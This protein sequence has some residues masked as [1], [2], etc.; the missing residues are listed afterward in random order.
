MSSIRNNRDRRHSSRTSRE[1]RDNNNGVRNDK[2]HDSSFTAHSSPNPSPSHIGE[3]SDTDHLR[4]N[5]DDLINDMAERVATKTATAIAFDRRDFYYYRRKTSGRRCS[6]FLSET[7]AD[8]GCHVCLGVGIIGGYE[9]H[10]TITETLDFTSPDLI[11]VNCE[12]NFDQDTR[13]V[14][15]RLI[16][17]KKLGYIETE[18]SVKHNVGKVDTFMLFQPIFNKGTKVTA[19]DPSGFGAELLRSEDLEPFLA[20]NKVRIRVEFEAG[21]AKPLISH[22]MF[23]YKLRDNLIVHGDIP[24]SEE[25]KIGSA[26]GFFED[27]QTIQIAFDGKQMSQYNNDDVLYRIRDGKRFKLITVNENRWGRGVLSSV[28]TTARFLIKDI[29]AGPINLLV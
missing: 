25:S 10:G 15:L 5:T 24:R 29:D 2:T 3:P 26:F 19:F 4:G 11:L 14:Y 23:R 28:D 6:C 8:S 12:P 22:F 27:L 1:L 7:S 17:E 21:D 9:K 18:F 16:D 13:P 20:N